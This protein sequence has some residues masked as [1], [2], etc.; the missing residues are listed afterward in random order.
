MNSTRN[1]WLK[2]VARQTADVMMSKPK[3][4]QGLPRRGNGSPTFLEPLEDRC[5]LSSILGSAAAYGVLGGSTVTNSGATTIVGDLGVSPG[6]SITGVSAGSVTGTINAGNASAVQAQVDLITAYNTL[7]GLP[8]TTNLT[9]QNLGGLTLTPGVYNFNAAAQLTGALTLNAQGNPNAQFVINIGSTLTTATASAVILIDGA[10]ADNVYFRIGSS[11]TIGP[12]TAFEGNILANTS[13]T[14]DPGATILDGRALAHNGAVTMVDN[15]VAI[16]EADISL[17][18]EIVSGAAVAGNNITYSVTVTDI[19]ANDAQNVVLSDLLPTHTTFVS[20]VQNSGPTFTLGNPAAGGT[21]T[22]T[23]V[24]PSLTVGASASFT[25][26]ARVLPGTPDGTSIVNSPAVTADTIDPNLANNSQTITTSVVSAAAPTITGVSPAEGATAGGTTVTIAGTNLENATAVDFGSVAVTSFISDSNS[27]IVLQSPAGTAGTIDV[28]ATTPGGTSVISASDLF[29]Y[30]TAPVNPV[31]PTA[32]T[33]TLTAPAN[34]VNPSRTLQFTA[35][36]INASG[37]SVALGPVTWSLGIGSTGS[38]DQ[39]GLYTAGDVGGAGETALVQATSGGHT[40]SQ[41]ITVN[42]V[43]P[44]AQ[45]TQVSSFKP[46][47]NAQSITGFVVTFNGPVDPTTAQNVGG[48][49]IVG[50]YTFNEHR[51]FLERLFGGH[52]GTDTVYA[53]YKIASAVYDSQT[54]SV[55]L[56]LGTSI[57]L[58]NG[59][60]WVEVTGTGSDAVLD[61]NGK[62]IDGDANG[63]AGGNYRESFGMSVTRSIS[64]PTASGELVNLSLSGPGEIVTLFPGDTDTPLINLID[65]NSQ[66]SILTGEIDKGSNSVASAV[67]D[68]LDGTANANIQLGDEFHINQNNAVATV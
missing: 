55:T 54:N 10:Q 61:A 27:Q 12:A 39:N 43:A 50:Q 68:E 63:T 19:G 52:S 32:A 7:A 65:T 47:G 18:G 48:Y 42:A 13:I 57:P 9:G 51:N 36:G 67:L 23:G 6:T 5:M 40:A 26:V 64:Y 56:T 28:T 60:L 21:G 20:D 17:T 49:Q 15:Q 8:T 2:S 25:I 29:T 44:G 59:M 45:I 38:I 46:V 30:G 35:A 31:T 22:I 34:N 1:A 3:V 24:T 62:P 53:G 14:L 11:A 16:P 66:N 37:S 41:S 58:G 4:R 33:L